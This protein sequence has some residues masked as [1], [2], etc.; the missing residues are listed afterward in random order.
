M[1]D[2][3]FYILTILIWGSTWI[4]IKLQLGV[5]DPM[6]S[7]SYRFLLA[8]MLLL[9][10]CVVKG[11]DL[12]FSLRSHLFMALQGALLFGFNYLLFYL[13]ELQ[14]T[15]GLAAV[16]FSTIVLM[17]MLNGALFLNKPID[18]RVGIGGII[19]LTGIVMVFKP[20]IQAFS[21]TKGGFVGVLLSLIAT[22]LASLG[23]I[24]SA[25]NQENHLPVVQSNAIG[26]G[27]GGMIML[28]CALTLGK[29]F[30][31]DPSPSYVFSL[32]YLS[33]FGSIIAFGCYLSLVGSIGAD[34]AAYATL[35]FPV[36]ALIISTVWEGYQWS[37]SA[38]FGVILIL[39]GNLWVIKKK[40]GPTRKKG[41]FSDVWR[42]V[43]CA[44]SSS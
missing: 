18:K 38:G 26:M 23:N 44:K 14:L 12:H 22:L 43:V 1:K 6:V 20:E 10:W 29:T 7:V 40:Q 31:F 21:I 24:V 42:K 36:V 25:Y 17:N 11:T 30:S 19:G 3:V 27:Y 16:V 39:C 37:W 32:L 34:R 28:I 4:G 5:V 2:L 9:L 15:S 8:S 13:A 35:L 33:I 41:G